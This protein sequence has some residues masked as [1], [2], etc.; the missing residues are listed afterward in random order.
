MLVVRHR[1]ATASRKSR[2]KRDQRLLPPFPSR[3]AS[4]A[5]LSPD[6]LRLLFDRGEERGPVRAERARP[7]ALQAFGKGAGIDA[8]VSYRWDR[9]F[10][11]R[12]VRFALLAGTSVWLLNANHRSVVASGADTVGNIHSWIQMFGT[13]WMP[14]GFTL[15][16]DLDFDPATDTY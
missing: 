10:R 9:P 12:V 11:R 1:A 14:P 6:L 4:L 8:G 2:V 5:G 13:A 16:G 15:P 7:V 3:S